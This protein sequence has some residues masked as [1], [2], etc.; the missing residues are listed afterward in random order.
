MILEKNKG[1]STTFQLAEGR[2][3][4]ISGVE[5]SSDNIRM[6]LSFNG[7]FRVYYED[8]VPEIL[9]LLQ[10]PVSML[11][12]YRTI[13]LGGLVTVFNKYLPNL[14]A[15]KIDVVYSYNNRKEYILDIQYTHNVGITKSVIRTVQFI[16]T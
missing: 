2:F 11:N 5:K 10:K 3:G 12:I 7:F 9:W 1:L 8:F 14:R 15:T 6:L 13:I 16:T 4:L